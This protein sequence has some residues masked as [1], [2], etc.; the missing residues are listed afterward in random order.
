[1]ERELWS[2]LYRLSRD[3][4]GSP[5]FA[6]TKFFRLGDRGRL[7]MGGTPRST[8]RLGLPPRE[9]ASALL[10]RACG[11]EGSGGERPRRGWGGRCRAFV[12]RHLLVR[13]VAREAN[14]PLEDAAGQQADDGAHRQCSNAFGFLDR[15]GNFIFSAQKSP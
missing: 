12:P 11:P 4:G 14:L 7:L 1:M 8:Y 2:S 5:W 15:I 9:L 10:G 3:L 13:R 6:V